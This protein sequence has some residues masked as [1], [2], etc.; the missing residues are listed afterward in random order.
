MYECKYCHHEFKNETFL[1]THIKKAKYCIKIQEQLNK[2]NMN[3]SKSFICEFCK[4]QLS[5]NSNLKVHYKTC[6]Q[7]QICELKK[8]IEKEYEE[9]IEEMKLLFEKEI[10]ELKNVHKKE[11]DA[12]KKESTNKMMLIEA[13]IFKQ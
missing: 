10:N 8:T 13:L 4:K 9:K 11:T 2:E 1:K 3:L 5:Q 12:L 7:K 6:K